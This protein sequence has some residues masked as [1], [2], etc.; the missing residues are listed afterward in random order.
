M[1]NVDALVA[2]LPR[3]G[4]GIGVTLQLTAGGA[5][6]G[7]V[8]AVILG[9]A[10]GHDRLMLRGAARVFVEVFRGTSLL[11]QLF[12]FVFVLPKFGLTLDPLTCGIIALALNYGAYGA[13]VVRGSINAVP[14]GQWEV[15][16]ALSMS[17]TRRMARIIFPQAWA[18]MI[19]SL[20]NLLIQ[21]LKGTALATFILLQDL[22]YMIEQL[23]RSTG[24]TI[25]AFGVGLAI[26]F[27]L[28]WLL[29]R[30]MYA[31]ELRARHRAGLA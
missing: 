10:A 7:L 25:F 24:D 21:L 29:T 8:V 14:R 15:A 6:F 27:G 22:N 12:W 1:G 23:Q 18:I 9:L 3:L 13:E 28:A 4:Q 5:A 17:R 2:A 31:L 30:L 26:Y 11:V 16:T 20:T 19:P